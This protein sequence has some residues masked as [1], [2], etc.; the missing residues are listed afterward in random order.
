MVTTEAHTH[1]FCPRP[2]LK[3]NW[4]LSQWIVFIVLARLSLLVQTADLNY[5]S[6]LLSLSVSHGSCVNVWLFFMIILWCPTFALCVNS[7]S[8]SVRKR[9]RLGTRY[10]MFVLRS[11]GGGLMFRKNGVS[12]CVHAAWVKCNFFVWRQRKKCTCWATCSGFFLVC[13]FSFSFVWVSLAKS[14]AVKRSFRRRWMYQEKVSVL[15][16]V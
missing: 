3:L 14:L 6:P 12:N 5:R 13:F 1:V 15:L 4:K 9:R 7:P 8:L 11:G 16:W 10:T 2:H